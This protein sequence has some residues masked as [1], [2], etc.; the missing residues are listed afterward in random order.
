MRK[1]W[2]CVDIEIRWICKIRELVS[3]VCE[4]EV[5]CNPVLYFFC[6]EN[7]WLLEGIF[8]MFRHNH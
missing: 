1:K 2:E 7:G 4:S 3:I 6:I 8:Q 5:M